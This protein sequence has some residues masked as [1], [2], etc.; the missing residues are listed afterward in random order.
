MESIKTVLFALSYSDLDKAMLN[1]AKRI[2][3]NLGVDKIYLINVQNTLELPEEILEKYPDYFV[4]KDETIK[5]ELNDVVEEAFKDFPVNYEIDVVAGNVT[6]EVLKWAKIKNVDLVI[7]GKEISNNER[8]LSHQKLVNLSPCSVLVLPEAGPD[9]FSRFVVPLDF[10]EN[11]VLALKRAIELCTFFEGAQIFAVHIYSVTSGY[12]FLGKDHD[13]F[14]DI[15]R[16]NAK[17]KYDSMMEGIDTKGIQVHCD[18]VQNEGSNVAKEIYKYALQKQATAIAL[19]S[20]GRTKLASIVRGSV[21][22]HLLEINNTFP[23]F[24]AKEKHHNMTLLEAL[25]D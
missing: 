22:E 18:Y 24:I 5:K 8:H 2:I 16:Q 14:A 19:G 23:L 17:K 1:Y 7:V 21:A 20:K 13:E 4:P 10:E 3:K 9:V 15:L 6:E 12:H 25:L 11:A